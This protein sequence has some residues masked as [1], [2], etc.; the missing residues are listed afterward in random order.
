MSRLLLALALLAVL[1]AT[2][3]PVIWQ[4]LTSIKSDAEITARPA[5]YWPHD[6]TLDSY[7]SLFERKP[8]LTYLGNSLK[9]ASLATALCLIAAIPAAYALRRSS[10][11]RRGIGLGLL[12]AVALFPPV[13]LLF[14]LYEAFRALGWLNHM[15]SL[16]LPYAALNLPLAIWALDSALGQIPPEVDDAAALDGLSLSRRLLLVQVPLAASG[17]AAA[18]ILVFIFSWNEF[19]LALTFMTRDESKTITAGIA[20]VSGS[21]IYEIPWGQLSAA[22]VIATA[23]LVALV[24]LAQRYVV[25]GVTRGAIKE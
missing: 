15:L 10:E 22:T 3:G 2:L 16:I 1:G 9:I 18:A 13:L 19:L 8:L 23:P 6:P 25:Q 4:L 17:I 20:S 24:L 12:A 11:R 7:Y 21:S 14:P 5:V